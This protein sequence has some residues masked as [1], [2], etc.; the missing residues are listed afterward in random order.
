[1]SN[2]QAWR[3]LLLLR[4]RSDVEAIADD[5]ALKRQPDLRALEDDS[6]IHPLERQARQHGLFYHKSR[7]GGNIGCY[8][9]GAGVAMSTMDALVAA[10][11]K[12]RVSHCLTSRPGSCEP[13]G[14]ER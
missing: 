5:F 14:D 1:M 7:T 8:G 4:I 13:K 12:V 2:S 9:Y 11:G 10:G 3:S 6:L